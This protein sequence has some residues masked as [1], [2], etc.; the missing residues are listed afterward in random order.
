MA[1]A[2]RPVHILPSR[3]NSSRPQRTLAFI[4]LHHTAHAR[5][6]VF[7]E[8]RRLS[9]FIPAA[10]RRVLVRV[11]V[12]PTCLLIW[13][14][15]ACMIKRHFLSA[16]SGLNMHVRFK[17]TLVQLPTHRPLARRVNIRTSGRWHYGRHVITGLANESAWLTG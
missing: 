16:K 1:S 11:R 10:I 5:A 17:A 14:D 9:A 4:A 8:R 2:I 6:L 3:G 15:L 7:G 12:R 13:V